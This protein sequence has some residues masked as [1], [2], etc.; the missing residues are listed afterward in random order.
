MV[1]ELAGQVAVF[2]EVVKDHLH[3]KPQ[4]AMEADHFGMALYGMHD[5]RFACPGCYLEVPPENF[6]LK[7]PVGIGNPVEARFADGNHLRM[8]GCFFRQRHIFFKSFFTN[9]P[10]VK[11]HRKIAWANIG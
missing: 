9:V 2:V 1:E 6:L 10:G 4:R 8:A 11:A 5:H 3:V 7:A